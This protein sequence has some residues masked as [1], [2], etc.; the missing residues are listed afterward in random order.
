MKTIFAIFSKTRKENQILIFSD[1][2]VSI[3]QFQTNFD[4]FK[5]TAFKTKTLREF[6]QTRKRKRTREREREIDKEIVP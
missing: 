2:L 6:Y 1:G 5:R 4:S 3:S